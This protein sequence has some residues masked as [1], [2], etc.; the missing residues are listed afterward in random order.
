M[1]NQKKEEG[2]NILKDKPLTTLCHNH[3]ILT[4]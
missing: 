2:K 4:Q 3:T 1:K